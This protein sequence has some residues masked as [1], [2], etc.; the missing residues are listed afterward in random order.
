[1]VIDFNRSVKCVYS[2]NQKNNTVDVENI[3][4][5]GSGE[6]FTDEAINDFEINNIEQREFELI[7]DNTFDK[8]ILAKLITPLEDISFIEIFCFEMTGTEKPQP[9]RFMVTLNST[10]EVGEM[11]HFSLTNIKEFALTELNISGITVAENK[12]ALLTVIV[13][14][15]KEY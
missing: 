6:D 11:S 15:K 4:Q 3:I 8:D 10:V 5:G 14:T 2:E 7:K 1:M 9:I 12:R 13:G